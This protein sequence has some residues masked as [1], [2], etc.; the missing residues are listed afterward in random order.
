MWSSFWAFVLFNFIGYRKKVVMDNIVKSFPNKTA[1]E[2]KEI[3]RKFYQHFCDLVVESIKIFSISEKQINQRVK[4]LNP[5]LMDELY[6]QGKQVVLAGGHYG[7]WEMFAVGVN[8]SMKHQ[9]VGIYFPIKNEFLNRKMK[10]SRSKYGLEMVHAKQVKP[11]FENAV[12]ENKKQVVIFATDQSPSN[13]R[14]AY[15]MEFLGRET[16]VLFGAEKYAKTYNCAL[17]YGELLKV[18]RGHYELRYTL[19]KKDCEDSEYGEITRLHT[20]TL[21]QTITKKPEHWLWSHRR[22][23]RTRPDDVEY[24]G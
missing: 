24:H 21:E 9:A 12:K 11:C 19:L 7:N 2:H 14:K 16:A 15:W 3:A 5:E 8:R 4:F 10:E 18:K 13:A 23:K 17:V 6:D 22:W 1:K 20:K